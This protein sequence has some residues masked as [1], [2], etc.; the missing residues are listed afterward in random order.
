MVLLVAPRLAPCEQL[1]DFSNAA[2]FRRCAEEEKRGGVWGL[3]FRVG[4]KP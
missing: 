3:G 1:P 2:F 4:P